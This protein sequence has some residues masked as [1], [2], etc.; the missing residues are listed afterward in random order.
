MLDLNTLIRKLTQGQPSARMD[1]VVPGLEEATA[2]SPASNPS[3]PAATASAAAAGP[4][5]LAAEAIA[6]R[7]YDLMRQELAVERARR[8]AASRRMVGGPHAR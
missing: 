3:A 8:G 1:L 7:V 6:R 4:P 2:S 5:D